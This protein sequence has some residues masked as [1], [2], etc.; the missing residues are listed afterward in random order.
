MQGRKKLLPVVVMGS[1]ALG[2]NPSL[3]MASEPIDQMNGRRFEQFRSIDDMVRFMNGKSIGMDMVQVAGTHGAMDQSVTWRE[4]GMQTASGGY[5]V[6]GSSIEAMNNY[7]ITI[8][9]V[10]GLTQLEDEEDAP[11]PDVL[12]LAIEFLAQVKTSLYEQFPKGAT[13]VRDDGSV[14]VYWRQP[15]R[16]VQLTVPAQ[17]DHTLSVYHREGDKHGTDTAVSPETLARWLE[18]FARA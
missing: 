11:S 14:D 1:M 18:W 7:N 17:Q 10:R 3:T 2:L 9:R 5:P 4:Q 12:S 6:H 13:A 8:E 15:G 16:I